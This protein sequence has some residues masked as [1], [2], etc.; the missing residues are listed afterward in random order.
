MVN[1][2]TGDILPPQR[3]LAV[4]LLLAALCTLI[5]SA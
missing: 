3:A 2:F 1:V 5:V 4:L